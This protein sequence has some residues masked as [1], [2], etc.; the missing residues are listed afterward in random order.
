MK[1]II[2]IIIALTVV[3]AIA[4]GVIIA[5]N[6]SGEH[7]HSIVVDEAKPATCL[8]T[9]L[10]EGSHC[11]TCGEVLKKQEIIPL[12]EHKPETVKGYA[13]T[14]IKAG[15]TDGKKC[16]YCDTVLEKQE[17]LPL[18]EHS[19]IFAEGREATCE[20]AGLTDGNIC[21]SCDYDT[22][23]ETALKA[24][25]ITDTY[26]Y[27]DGG[28]WK[29]CSVCQN[30][31]VA[32]EVH[33]ASGNCICGYGCKHSVI[34]E[35]ISKPATCKE[36]G[37]K[38]NIC[39][40][41]GAVIS[42]ESIEKLE[43]TE[44]TLSRVEPTCTKE[45]LTEGSHCSVCGEILK[46]QEKI[47]AKGHTEKN[48]YSKDEASHWKICSVCGDFITEKE[49]HTI[50][51][52]ACFCGYTDVCEHANKSWVTAKE[53]S[54]S[55]EGRR[56]E[57]CDECGIILST[58]KTEKLEHTEQILSKREPSCTEAGLTEGVK[59]SVCGEIL[60]AQEEIPA[61][62]HTEE[63][64][65]EQIS[66]TCTES[67]KATG[68][69]CSVCS[70]VLKASSTVSPLG[71]NL[72]LSEGVDATCTEAGLTEG[73]TCSRCDYD[74]RTEI[75]K[76]NHKF[77]SPVIKEVG[78]D[79][80]GYI[81]NVC[82]ICTWT[83]T[84]V[85][86]AVGHS[87]GEW[88]ITS[89]STC[90]AEGAQRCTCANCG[91]VWVQ[92][93]GISQHAYTPTEEITEGGY[94]FIIY[95]CDVCSDEYR[96]RSDGD[97]SLI[98]ED[99]NE[100]DCPIDYAFYIKSDKSE[101]YIRSN[102]VLFNSYF[103]DT[104]YENHEESV[105]SYKLTKT[106]A[107][108]WKITPVLNY[109]GGV[110]YLAR[111]TNNIAFR[112]YRSSKLYFT[113]VSEE[114]GKAV[115]NEN[116]IFIHTLEKTVGGYYPYAID[117]NENSEYAYLKLGNV[118]G[119]NIGSVICVGEYESFD[120][121]IADQ[122]PN[123]L[124]GKIYSIERSADGSWLIT[125][126]EAELDEIFTE[127]DLYQTT[128]V[129]F[130]TMNAVFADDAEEMA[131]SAL[132]QSDE[133][134][135]FLSSVNVA[136]ERYLRGRGMD[137]NVLKASSFLD[138]VTVTP[139]IRTSGTSCYIDLSGKVE[140]PI[141]NGNQSYG[142]L[143]VSF[144]A[145]AELSFKL[146]V[147]CKVKW[148][149]IFYL[150]SFDIQVRQMD[151][152]GFEFSVDFDVDYSL[153]N[154]ADYVQYT[155][156]SGKKILHLSDCH[157]ISGDNIDKSK[158]TELSR[159]DMYVK[160]LEESAEECKICQPGTRLSGMCYA[161]NKGTGVFHI[162]SCTHV[163]IVS[164]DKYDITPESAKELTAAG[165]TA[166]KDC[167]PGDRDSY[168]FS[169]AIWD[170][171]AY[172]SWE[173]MVKEI[174]ELAKNS[175]L[176]EE[177]KKNFKLFSL[178]VNFV[179]FKANLDVNLSLEFKVTTSLNYKYEVKEENIYGVRY[180]GKRTVSYKN[181]VSKEVLHND[182]TIMGKASFR[183]GVSVDFHA[184]LLG[185]KWLASA[186][187][188]AGVGIYADASGVAHTSA[189]ADENYAAARLECGIYINVNIYYH[190]LS[191]RGDVDV[192]DL[193]MRL[194][195]LGYDKAYFA[196][197]NAPD[198]MNITGNTALSRDELLNVKY[199][200]L[201]TMTDKEEL[202]SF[203]G[204][205]KQYS[206]SVS[207]KNG[208]WLS[209]QNGQIIVS[210]DAPCGFTDI[211]T[212][213]VDGSSSW[214]NYV[215]GNC[216]FY[217]DSYSVTVNYSGENHSYTS[218]VSKEANCLENGIMLYTCPSCGDSYTEEIPLG[219]HAYENASWAWNGYNEAIITL[220][221]RYSTSHTVAY[222]VIPTC[223]TTVEADCYS[224]GERV[225]T[226]E[227]V[228]NGASYIDTS[229]EITSRDYD[230]HAEAYYT[231][232]VAE[233]TC[234]S[235]GSLTEKC[236]SCGYENSEVLPAIKHIIDESGNCTMCGEHKASDG[237][238][239]TSVNNGTAYEIFDCSG[240]TDTEVYIPSTYE[241][242]PVVRIGNLAFSNNSNITSLIIPHSV[243]EIYTRALYGLKGILE[244]SVD[245]RNSVYHSEGN[246]LIETATGVLVKGTQNSVIPSYVT[247]IG[248]GAFRGYSGLDSIVIPNGIISIDAYAFETTPLTSITLPSSLKTIG[249][250]AFYWTYLEALEIPHGV[251][252]IG[253]NAFAM[254]G[255]LKTLSLPN[256]LLSI[257]DGA[258][259]D[260]NGLKSISIPASV[261][262]IGNGAFRGCTAVTGITVDAAN[263]S[264]Y[265]EGN[266]LIE[267]A[268]KTLIVG[269]NNSSIPSG[270]T[271]IGDYA[272]TYCSKLTSITVPEGVSYIG[273]NAFDG[274]RKLKTVSLPST[275]ESIGNSA[276]AS[277][278]ALSAITVPKNVISI[279]T[280]LFDYCTAL[281]TVVFEDAGGWFVTKNKTD[282]QNAANGTA[283]DVSDSTANA[284]YF[285]TTYKSYYWYKQ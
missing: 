127:V 229:T 1:K 44:E 171:V 185:M 120:D 2:G 236:T 112:D 22:R 71:H 77:G 172:S 162:M 95:I 130:D 53:A 163:G 242:L 258:F 159:E 46:A 109:E 225:Y 78:C 268:T 204:V 89:P 188:S 169:D 273:R 27:D 249:E 170:S 173:Q 227:Y 47:S 231:A 262:D 7:K 271:A 133:F 251:T 241:G 217:I 87:Y 190:I 126:T 254:C 208:K 6:N 213:K 144:N 166:C 62:G 145:S 214:K 115:I 155:A 72:V 88:E 272:F 113:T 80:D 168:E 26:K 261:T 65:G 210:A 4:A 198:E 8:E 15:K 107:D 101:E 263:T 196:F 55:A 195:A 177:E 94:G 150:D 34:S 20:K 232:T 69:K 180:Q 184:N 278:S 135:E 203:A 247:S 186:G 54:C 187:V 79:G 105:V 209:Y 238:L 280:G 129:D 52:G 43:H 277:C 19:L 73:H 123:C 189:S 38:E 285:K 246:C 207:F 45:G 255:D 18:G 13:S 267:S 234:T 132:Y 259:E 276:F 274:C 139:T 14:C 83:E 183:F 154:P 111:I 61:L 16:A 119:L 265:S 148:I 56:E 250:S 151:K 17:D 193:K 253:K 23:T 257:G 103:E 240:V 230:R 222:S 59:C 100:F 97:Q 86:F 211:M 10:T 165:K 35:Q 11:K 68:I 116:V 66:P 24:H 176:G 37:R 224:G 245:P 221:C 202:L 244:I 157:A 32:K 164:K 74:S 5:L 21:E 140:I 28:H 102:L 212:V 160:F 256:T 206:I 219:A 153:V 266:C 114:T 128:V 124:F 281:K 243:A 270:I 40:D 25:T 152:L 284:A 41:C 158:L 175:G 161:V 31:S 156:S 233:A 226:A 223:K 199:F 131:V 215:Q 58:D 117:C 220:S 205:K 96:I 138:M 76:T 239:F 67:G 75:P 42:F 235:L 85:L 29:E 82:S 174:G 192:L 121:I 282:W 30:I 178:P 134:I 264:Y 218:S 57:I 50:T 36:E 142:N 33:A 98:Y 136:S 9:G 167:R 60:K 108:E 197:V 64:I 275:L 93:L 216:A 63:I 179:V 228:Y 252:S 110:T 12:A 51:N 81:K 141:Q 147:N 279:G 146:S 92:R 143:T 70:T 137:T 194:I 91:D 201:L 118:Y 248:Y 104:E 260:C 182:L 3:A 125:L 122:N 237:F 84:E 99:T 149:F 39:S 106:G 181:T 191:K 48:E 49:V 90:V 269:C 200:D 283:L